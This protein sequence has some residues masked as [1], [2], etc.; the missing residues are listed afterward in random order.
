MRS[1]SNLK[2]Q[3]RSRNSAR[4]GDRLIHPVTPRCST[5]SE[6]VS[7]RRPFGRLPPFQYFP[8]LQLAL[9]TFVG[10]V[11]DRP[12][13]HRLAFAEAERFLAYAGVALIGRSAAIGVR[14]PPHNKQAMHQAGDL[15]GFHATPLPGGRT[16]S[17]GP[18]IQLNAP[19]RDA[20]H[21]CARAPGRAGR[22]ART[23]Q[24]LFHRSTRRRLDPRSSDLGSPT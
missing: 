15:H 14:S 3:G 21:A 22:L 12:V 7:G 1:A 4:P 16:V 13:Q 18:H 8:V 5:G 9:R 17:I 24:R 19:R 20:H 10:I 11:A 23:R 6:L 2:T